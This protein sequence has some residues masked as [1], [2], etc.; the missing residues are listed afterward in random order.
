MNFF[1]H[2]VFS[3]NSIERKDILNKGMNVNNE[4]VKTTGW[5]YEKLTTE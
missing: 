1:K 2:V 4:I 3:A 5:L